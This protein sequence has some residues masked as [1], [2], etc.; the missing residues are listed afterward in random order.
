MNPFLYINEGDPLPVFAFSYLGWIPGDV[1]NEAY[2]VLRNTDQA[3]MI[4]H[5]PN[6]RVP[7]RLRPEPTNDNYIFT[8][9]T[10]T[11]HVNPYGPG[12]RAVK[13][14]LNCIREID[15]DYYMA[16]FEYRNDNDVA[17]YVP[18]GE[19]N[20]FAG[21]GVDWANS[22]VVPSMFESGGGSFVVF[23][24]GS[25][26]SWVVNSRDGDQKVRNAAN[27]N[28]S[29]TKCKGN[30]KSASVTTD[31]EEELLVHT[32]QLVAYPNPVVDW[33]SISMEDIEEYRMVTIFDLAGRS[34]P[35]TSIQKRADNLDIDMSDLPSGQYMIRLVLQESARV[36]QVIKH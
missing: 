30:Y 12:T 35:V 33:V 6:L 15:T 29:S 13:P 26:L 9:E 17:V 14:I 2:T 34:Y 5:H 1:G 27:A 25:E 7:I 23:F 11:L 19:D 16:N 32:D 31:V 21:S 20:V 22:G 28:S 3:H 10:G 4:L 18:L 8:T 24:D 36:V